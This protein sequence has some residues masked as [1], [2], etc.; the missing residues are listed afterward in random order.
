M[1]D[2]AQHIEK[3]LTENECVIIPHFGGFITYY[4]PAQWE[5]ESNMF[6]PPARMIRFN[7]RL[8]IND[9]LLIQ[10]YMETEGI[11]FAEASR[12][13][14]ADIR[15]W[16]SCLHQDGFI[17]LP[18]IG[19]LRLSLHNTF[20]F[21]P[22][23]QQMPSAEWYGLSGFKIPKLKPHYSAPN[24]AVP[25]QTGKM[26][27]NF[28]VRFNAPLWSNIAAVAA[29]IILFFAISI[30]VKNTEIINGN[31]AQ[32]LPTEVF[33]QLDKQ[34]LAFTPL[35]SS[36]PQP[37]S[38]KKSKETVSVTYPAKPSISST[39]HTAIEKTT[40]PRNVEKATIPISISKD[41]AH[42]SSVSEKKIYHIIVASVSTQADAEKMASTLIQAGHED[43]KAIIGDG[44]MRV[45]IHSYASEAEAYQAVK[46]LRKEKAY[47]NAWVLKKR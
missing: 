11:S 12:Q 37:K 21:I 8:T 42:A 31:Y 13:M 17:E 36:H 26:P 33:N 41:V 39:T 44:K 20:E 4:A 30:P 35:V 25:R 47:Q 34:S 29:I 9:G 45:S 28:K 7:P 24:L 32:L 14:Q 19:K 15:Q 23:A 1:I 46:Q 43:A 22:E 38:E 5:E 2:L 40:P 10:S 3:L 16:V 6:L 27:R 18:H